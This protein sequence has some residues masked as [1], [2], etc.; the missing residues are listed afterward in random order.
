MLR[1]RM[2]HELVRI[3]R[4]VLGVTLAPVVTDGVRKHVSI[5]VEGRSRD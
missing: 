4:G 3:L 5:F 2:Q 1:N